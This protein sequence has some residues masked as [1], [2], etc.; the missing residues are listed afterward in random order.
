MALEQRYKT[1]EVARKDTK[2]AGNCDSDGE[3]CKY[4]SKIPPW[5]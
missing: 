1:D 5:I 4:S 3:K 2:M